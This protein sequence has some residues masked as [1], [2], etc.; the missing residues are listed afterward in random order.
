MRQ[1]Y[2][3]VS[4]QQIFFGWGEEITG[5]RFNEPATNFDIRHKNCVQNHCSMPHATGPPGHGAS[6]V[7]A[8]PGK[9][10]KV[11][12]G[13]HD[14]VAGQEVDVIARKGENCSKTRLKQAEECSTSETS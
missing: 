1:Y 6:T 14:E 7:E 12:V 8:A 3:G 5:F 10:G 2:Q 9:V 13:E 4:Q 11:R